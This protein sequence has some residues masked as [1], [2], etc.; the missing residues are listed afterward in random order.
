MVPLIT[1]GS[2]IVAESFDGDRFF[3]LLD[4]FAPTWY[5]AGPTYHKAVLA[6]ASLHND[7]IVRRPL[8]FIRSSSAPLAPRTMAE[9]EAVFNAPVLEGYGLTETC[10]HATSNPPPPASRK[11]GCVGVPVCAEVA[12]ADENG[13]FMDSGNTGEVVLRG[14]AITS[15]Y[16][17]NPLANDA[18]FYGDWFRTGDQGY[19][20]SDGYL[21][22]T[23]R[24]KE[25]I[26]RGGENIAPVE[27]DHT[28]L[29][30]PD[31]NEAVAFSIPHPTLG[32]EVGVAIV[33]RSGSA[34]TEQ[35]VQKHASAS[36]ASFK[37]PRTVLFV[38]A[39]PKS[40][41]GKSMRLGLAESL[42]VTAQL[43]SNAGKP[44]QTEI[45]KGI[46]EV[47]Q[48]LLATPVPGVDVNFFALGGDSLRAV[49]AIDDVERRFE[50]SLDSGVIFDSGSTVAG[51]AKL[52]EQQLTST[53]AI[54]PGL[55]PQ[56]ETRASPLPASYPQQAF[57]ILSRIFRSEPLCNVTIALELVGPLKEEAL[58]HAIIL[59]ARRHEAL[60]TELR[61]E[62]G[63]LVQVASAATCP[64]LKTKQ[65]N[66]NNGPHTAVEWACRE[67]Q[68]PFDVTNK[69]LWRVSLLRRGEDSHVL[70]FVLHHSITD[71]T[72]C[73][74]LAEDLLSLYARE[75]TSTEPELPPLPLHYA[76]F[77][78]WQRRLWDKGELK[79][80]LEYWR[81][82]LE[83]APA[84]QK[85]PQDFDDDTAERWRGHKATMELGI[86]ETATLQ[87][88]AKD[89]KATLFMVLLVGYFALLHRCTLTT[90]PV[91]GVPF[92]NRNH[93]DFERVVGCFMNVLP[94]RINL[95]SD[96]TLIEV[97]TEV[98]RI[99]T[100]AY[101]NQRV[102]KEILSEYFTTPSQIGD[103]GLF[104]SIFQLRNYQANLTRTI[105]DLRVERYVLDSG[106][107]NSALDIDWE[108]RDRKLRCGFTY[109][110]ASFAPATIESWLTCY[111]EILSTA[112]TTPDKHVSALPGPGN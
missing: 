87:R 30:H 34:I 42:N 37:V 4:S 9:L 51:L 40:T 41:I 22:L 52:V 84:I 5:T 65:I 54:K 29:E 89:N 112:S 66:H 53:N 68:K 31:I 24:Y 45:E 39:I 95:R 108:L 7:V 76:D 33:R 88:V 111:R 11:P 20:D 18:A 92:A 17:K 3:S 85:L 32:E 61:S 23:G 14:P 12:I 79:S 101:A 82:R 46:A 73:E 1:G 75:T 103:N 91:V 72:S 69:P 10:M 106:I 21:I 16:E 104:D 80:E 36:L 60:R 71:G 78:S 67:S 74:V 50:V 83:G 6:R 26:N 56:A 105:A 110:T 55:Q 47:W 58:Q 27:I 25:M 93:R 99:T 64:A 98:R 97:L 49:Y 2:A 28:L 100:D 77:S 44:P 13:S 81:T 48:S 38:D 62:N 57:W 15:G 109:R 43:S 86:S 102:P 94:L 19:V 70:L 8:R 35:D 90:N 59:L 107:A 96:S 63:E